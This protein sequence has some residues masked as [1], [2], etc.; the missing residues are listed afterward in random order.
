[1]KKTENIEI[2]NLQINEL[3]QRIKKARKD[4]AD[5]LMDK[6]MGQLKDVKAVW[7]KKK[8]LAQ[9]LT[10]LRQKQLLAELEPVNQSISESEKEKMKN[11]KKRGK[12]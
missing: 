12:K 5:L 6:N 4:L 10:I 7:K 1:M 3:W 11:S 8:D 2:K 9:M